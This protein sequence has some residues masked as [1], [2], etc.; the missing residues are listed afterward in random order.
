VFKITVY[1]FLSTMAVFLSGCKSPKVTEPSRSGIEQLLLSDAVDDALE[2]QDIPYVEGRK[3]FLSNA[4]LKSYDAEYVLGS[5]RA[6]LSENGAHLVEARGDADVIVEARSGAIG[7][8]SSSTL[9]GIPSIPLVIPAAGSIKLPD[10]ALYKSAKADSIAKI[11][12]LAY[13]A[14]GAPIFSS[15]SYV[16]S[17]GFH[18]YTFLF[19]LDVNI[20][21]IPERKRY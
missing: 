19:L 16:G 5:I 20:T 17:S 21:D 6:K 4:F 2:R 8:D 12:L 13:E 18:Q 11:A 1:A 14:D 10:L 9:F 15:E 3:V 7:I